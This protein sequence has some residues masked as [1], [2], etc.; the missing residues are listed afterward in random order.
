VA[1]DSITNDPRVDSLN[2]QS[3]RLRIL[4]VAL[5]PLLLAVG[6]FAAY[7][8]HRTISD[9]EAY[10][11][12]KGQEATR[13]LAETVA[14]DLFTGN[15]PNAKRL[16]DLE[17]ASLTA[18]SVA[19]AENGRWTLLSGHPDL[20]AGLLSP[21]PPEV[22][23]RGPN[24][25]FSY[26]VPTFVA[27]YS[28]ESVG[29]PPT[30]SPGANPLYVV[31]ILNR[32]PVDLARSQVVLA[33]MGMALFS[34]AVALTLAWRI[35]GNV[36]KPLHEITRTIDY[37]TQGALS[38]RV[39]QNASGE[40][41]QLQAGVNLMAQRLEESQQA[42]EQRVLDATAELRAQKAQAESATLAKS[43]FLAAASHDLRQPLHALSLLVEAL[44]ERVPE[45]EAKHLANHIS[46]SVTA[47]EKLLNALLDLS[48]LDAG[49][50]EARPDCFPLS[51][52]LDSI[53]AQFSS[54]AASQG[55]K[56]VV[57]NTRLWVYSDAALLERILANLVANALRYTDTGRVLVGARRI[58]QD[59]IR[60]EV[61]DSGKGI[62]PEFQIRV[63]E[64]YFQLANPE[65][66]R[67]K[68]LGLG[69]AIVT[70]LAR[71]LGTQ[72]QVHS[73]PQRGSCFHMRFARCHA[74]KLEDAKEESPS[75]MALPLEKA[76]VA[77]I[78]DD[79]SILEAMVEVF[80][81]WGVA[82]AAGEDGEQ[83]R[84]ELLELGR[85]PDVILSDYRLKHG[86]TGIDAIHILQASFGPV[87]AAL[88]TG[89]TATST[90]DE[91]EASG[92]P[93]LHKPLKPAK[94]RAFLSHLLAAAGLKASATSA[95]QTGSQSSTAT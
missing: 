81:H 28:M 55:L 62:P 70:R 34:L 54:V 21:V 8:A 7:F 85:A 2:T 46:A 37:L 64:E 71:L 45:G 94:L 84:R 40:L 18:E 13:R 1:A 48:R 16:L 49:V 56:L 95:S 9:A 43:R 67:D 68:G 60:V 35:A 41:G 86:Q 61:W 4:A 29:H 11:I 10:L 27:T 36:S 57:M 53:E 3:L 82:L 44:E 66:H 19:V 20:L 50:V 6:L 87:P 89:D 88:L 15:L 26:P 69:L 75:A 74:R 51:R 93:V 92:F 73:Q 52:V 42:L 83:V 17:R 23:R 24:F 30:A 72:V 91:I 76:L 77:F 5:L 33:A 25:I 58:Q 59:W 63:F 12:T 79:K 39:E 22:S 80:D 78:D 47:M 32:K 38:R 14:F 65:R 90:L 31:L